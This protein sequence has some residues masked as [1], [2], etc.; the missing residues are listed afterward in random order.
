MREIEI[1]GKRE[2]T[3]E[4]VY[5]FY[6][7]ADEKHYIFTGKTGLSQV[8]PVHRLMYKDFEKYE[9]IP[10]TV[11]QYT[12]LKA[13]DS[14]RY[15]SV[16]GKKEKDLRIFEGDIVEDKFGNT[17]VIKY[18]DHFLDWRIVFFKGRQD[19]LNEL[20]ARI[21]EWVYPKI[22]LKV[23]GNRWDNPELLSRE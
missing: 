19:L 10:E 20:G 5:G 22:M 14:N 1:R 7:V 6:V 13:A 4:W 17:G 11:G 3:G 15:I 16:S 18:S 23:I 9:V 12:G 8:T 21:F 2:D